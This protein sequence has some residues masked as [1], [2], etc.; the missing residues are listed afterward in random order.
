MRQQSEK[1]AYS[2]ACSTSYLV[3]TTLQESNPSTPIPVPPHFTSF[4]QLSRSCSACV[5][6]G[7]QYGA[8]ASM[9]DPI[10][11]TLF[12][13]TNT[14]SMA[15]SA[16]SAKS[17]VYILYQRVMIQGMMIVSTLLLMSM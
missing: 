4:R 11:L 15:T 16:S 3:C 17:S 2:F 9:G 13:S 12:V 8:Y 14:N 6:S 1:I 10:L 5:T 7:C